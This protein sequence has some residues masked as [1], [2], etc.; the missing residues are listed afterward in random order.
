MNF[1]IFK[2]S[3]QNLENWLKLNNYKAYDPFEG[4]NS[5]IRFL[6]FER[7]FLRQVL[8]QLFRRCPFNI[9]PLFG[10]KPT[11]SSKG[12]AYLIKGYLELYEDT[13]DESY[14]KIAIDF[15]DKLKNLSCEGYSG[16]SWGNHFDYQT[17]GYFLKKNNPTLVWTSL[18]GRAFFEAFEILKDISY[19]DIVI[20][21]CEFVI[22][23][24]N[25]Y[26][27]ERSACLS[28]VTHTKN[29]IHNANL[30]GASLLALGYKLT[31]NK[32]YFDV[33][34]SSVRYSV[35]H[36]H[37]DGSW[38][39]GQESKYHWIDNWHT[40]YNLDAIKIYTDATENYEFNENLKKGF[41]FYFRN[42]FLENGQPKYY[43]NKPGVVDIQCCSQS[44][45]TLVRFKQFH[46]ESLNVAKKVA[47]WTIKNMQDKDG[48]FY[49]RKGRVFTNKVPM[50][51]WGQAT[52]FYALVK[53][54]T[55]IKT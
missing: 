54:L 32:N 19:K 22:N 17:R 9:R 15:L 34:T 25:R 20:G 43:Y 53:L 52:M 29:L 38:Y 23:N 11:Q 31:G 39:Y 26:G 7:V 42:F 1:I 4:L 16:Y 51:H 35:M 50:F 14:K 5:N 10:I 47:G 6:T 46:P 13:N 12:L 37:E 2:E 36:Q 40:A 45:E 27:D 33:A 8:V 24:I 41:D 55:N 18:C 21:A 44:I 3:L 30:L 49:Y 48:H 28:Y